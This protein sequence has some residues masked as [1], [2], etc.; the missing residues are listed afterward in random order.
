M[1]TLATALA[2]VAMFAFAGFAQAAETSGRII[3][4]DATMLVL[5]DGTAITIPEGMDVSALQP[6]AEV[7]VSYEERDGAKVATAVQPAK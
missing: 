6:G 3:S 7:M 4:M 2:V 5:E 1:K